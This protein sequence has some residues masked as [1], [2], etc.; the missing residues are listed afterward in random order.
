M[1]ITVKNKGEFENTIREYR[2]N[3]YML[4][5]LWK[6]FAELENENEI[7]VIEIK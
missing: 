1:S 4:I 2:E 5:T 7:V 6:K 3:G